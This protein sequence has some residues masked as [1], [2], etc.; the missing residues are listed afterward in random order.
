MLF[1]NG[2]ER[3]GKEFSA[4]EQLALPFDPERGFLGEPGKAC[5]PATPEWSYTEPET[6]FSSFISGCQRLPNGNTLVCSGAQGRFFEVTSAGKIVWEYWNPYGGDLEATFGRAAPKDNPPPKVEP[7]AVF[8]ATR[9][10][11]DDPRLAGR[12]LGE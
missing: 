2:K 12:K 6:F 1:N 9:I 3:P 4:I 7:K 5:G 8:R 11:R 10:A